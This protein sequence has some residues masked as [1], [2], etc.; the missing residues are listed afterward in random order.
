MKSSRQLKLTKSGSVYFSP[1]ALVALSACG[2]GGGSPTTSGGGAAAAGGAVVKGPL[3]NALVFIDYDQDGVQGVGEPSAVTG[4]DGSYSITHTDTTDTTFDI[5]AIAGAG[6]IDASSGSA[7][8]GFTLSAPSDA[9]VVTPATTMVVESGGAL[10]AADV[11]DILNLPDGVDPLTF[12]PYGAGVNAADAL[13]V[14]KVAQQLMGAINAYSASLEGAGASSAD[15]FSVA[16]NSVVEVLKD[17]KLSGDKLDITKS[18]DLDLIAA[19][20]DTS[21]GASAPAGL[22]ANA[23]TSMKADTRDAVKA[24]ADNISAVSSLDD[25]K[26]SFGNTE[27]LRAQIK[28]AAEL[29]AATP[30]AGVGQVAFTNPDSVASSALNLAPTDLA[31]S[32]SSISEAA[33]SLIVGT[34]TTTDLDQPDGIDHKYSIAQ[35]SGEDFA[36]FSI[37]E[38]TGELA[39]L[40]QPDFETKSS[41]KVTI[42]STD[43]GGKSITEKF[44]ITIEDANDPP[45]IDNITDIPV[46]ENVDVTSG[47][48]EAE[49]L[50]GDTVVYLVKGQVDNGGVFTKAGTYGTL[51]LNK[52]SGAYSY[53]LDNTNAT[54]DDLLDATAES[55]TLSESFNIQLDDGNYIVNKTISFKI[56]GVNDI[57]TL[58]IPS[59]G[60]VVEEAEENEVTGTITASDSDS[61]LPVVSLTGVTAADGAFTKVGTYGTLVLNEATPSGGASSNSYTYTLNNEDPDTAA[62]SGADVATESFSI[63]VTDEDGGVGVGTLNIEIQGYGVTVADVAG[64]NKINLA[65]ATAGFEITGRGNPGKEITLAFSGSSVTLEGGNSVTVN[66]N[67]DWSVSVTAADVEGMGQGAETLTASLAL[68][69]STT[70]DSAPISLSV[71]TAAPEVAITG[72]ELDLVAKTIT[73]N[74]SGFNGVGANGVDVT[75]RVDLTKFAWDIDGDGQDLIPFTAETGTLTVDSDTA[76]IMQLTDDAFAAL[77]AEPGFAADGIGETNLADKLVVADGAFSDAAGNTQDGGGKTAAPSYS[78]TAKPLLAGFSSTSVDAGASKGFPLGAE[79]NI[80]ATMEEPVLG[81]STITVTL[82]TNDEVVLTAEENGTTLVGILAV[83]VN[84]T[85]DALAVQS[86]EYTSVS[87]LYGNAWATGAAGAIPGGENLSDYATIEIDTGPPETVINSVKYKDSVF[88]QV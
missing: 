15:S 41:Y 55:N 68:D 75:A 70:V 52:S 79:I 42:K 14:E 81:G 1:L 40:A 21:I 3:E 46:I 76:L 6:T 2:G 29:E 82:S 69:E 22:T 84:T 19:E 7:V 20:V 59:D 9:G 50:N 74:G 77:I 54:V 18:S 58:V 60:S 64:D 27:V 65:E 83:P 43:S 38:A 67:G 47:T 36:A 23:W 33:E 48:L 61:E 80:T 4:S 31:I 44:T 32:S 30:G 63:T 25:G 37:N 8:E 49:D 13:A 78:D 45:T 5:V 53:A 10:S 34:V 72:V 71:D 85:E 51:T 73:A 88:N 26:G 56:N 17:K 12:N 57:A 62:L 35:V 28:A 16:M 39:I 87:D 24:V 11:A 66:E 86:F